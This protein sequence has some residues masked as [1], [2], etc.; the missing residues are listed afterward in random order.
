MRVEMTK[1]NNDP[2]ADFF[3][4]SSRNLTPAIAPTDLKVLFAPLSND[5]DTTRICASLMSDQE[6]TRADRF[7]TEEIKAQFIQRR[8]FRRYCGAR[9]LKASGTGLDNAPDK[10]RPLAQIDFTETDKGRPYLAARPDIWFSFSACRLGF[11]GAYS[12]G[13]AVGVDIEDHTKTLE[14]AELAERYFTRAEA[15]QIEKLT[16]GARTNA[17]YQF[18]TLKEAALKSIGEGLGFGL[19]AFEFELAPK[20]SLLRAPRDKGGPSRFDAHLIGD[21]DV[22]AALVIRKLT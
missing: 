5:P 2:V 22:T 14:A 19:D 11:L 6:R 15:D 12:P 21:A 4:M 17:F 8:A 3:T 7:I 9:A 1:N 10:P 20:P 18:W 13:Y 16:A